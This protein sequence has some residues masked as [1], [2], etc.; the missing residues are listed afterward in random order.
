M[1]G[2][3]C[4]TMCIGNTCTSTCNS[5]NSRTAN[6]AQLNGHSNT[7]WSNSHTSPG[8]KPYISEVINIL[9]NQPKPTKANN[10]NTNEVITAVDKLIN[11]AS[12]VAEADTKSNLSKFQ[13]G[14]LIGL[15]V[16]LAPEAAIGIASATLTALSIGP[17]GEV[18]TLEL[19][20]NPAFMQAATRAGAI[21]G[22]GKLLNIFGV[23]K[24]TKTASN[25]IAEHPCT[26]MS[27]EQIAQ[28]ALDLGMDTPKNS[29]I[30]WSGLGEGRVGVKLSQ[31]FATKNGG[32][33]LE[34]TAG[35]K[36]LDEMGLFEAS[37]PLSKQEAY[38]VWKEVSTKAV[39]KASGDVRAVVG[40][41]R[42]DSIYNAELQ[43]LKNNPNV[44]KEID[45]LSILP[46]VTMKR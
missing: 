6:G 23:F 18:L 36:W 37:S 2:R 32:I 4:G 21:L 8:E 7:N 5:S 20:A 31:E 44:T 24:S 26:G 17:V 1:Q 40:Q 42:V 12:N 14:I 38:Q 25:I 19:L 11:E 33:T 10:I 39:S 13:M 22:G 28:K 46:K 45:A 9:N 15:G 30:L 41:V 27:V 34:M 35:G 29:L 43:A 3:N 16:L